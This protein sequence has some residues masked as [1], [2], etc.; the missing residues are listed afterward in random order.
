MLEVGRARGIASLIFRVDPSG[1]PT[2]VAQRK[3]FVDVMLGTVG[4]YAIQADP[5]VSGGVV[6]VE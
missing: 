2:E 4:A 5:G 1:T 3:D 6:A